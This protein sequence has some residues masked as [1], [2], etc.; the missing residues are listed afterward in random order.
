[1]KTAYIQPYLGPFIVEG[2]SKKYNQSKR[3]NNW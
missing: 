3:Q 2:S 1:M